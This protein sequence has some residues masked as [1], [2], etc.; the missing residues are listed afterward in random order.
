[1]VGIQ[2]IANTGKV[3]VI[4]ALVPLQHIEDRVFNTSQAGRGSQFIVLSRVVQDDVQDHF[5][6][7]AMKGLNH[8]LELLNLLTVQ[9]SNAVG[10]L[11][12]KKGDGIIAPVVLEFLSC[13][14]IEEL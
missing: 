6:A 11:R 12:S 9:S 10:L 8:L 3:L 4:S 14:G 1:V 2:R 13:D 7:G 5:N